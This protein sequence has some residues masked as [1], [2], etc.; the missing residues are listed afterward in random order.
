MRKAQRRSAT[1]REWEGEYRRSLEE[2][3]DIHI[4]IILCG[5]RK[6]EKKEKTKTGVRSV[7]KELLDL[8]IL[9]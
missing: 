9:K 1:E 3:M 2:E 7:I 5:A 6:Q 8:W 4:E